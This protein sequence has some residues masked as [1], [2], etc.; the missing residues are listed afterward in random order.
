MRVRLEVAALVNRVFLNMQANV[1]AG[2][3]CLN[4]GILFTNRKLPSP[5]PGGS[6]VS[7]QSENS[8]SAQD[9][10]RI[11]PTPTMRRPY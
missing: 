1:A 7:Q 5:R 3:R 2:A 9:Y 11:V 4:M 10:S 8:Y 6:V